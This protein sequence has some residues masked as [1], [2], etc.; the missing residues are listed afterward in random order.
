MNNIEE[1]MKWCNIVLERDEG[2][3]DAVCNKAELH[4][5]RQEYEEA[6]KIYQRAGNNQDRRVSQVSRCHGY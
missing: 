1:G 3:V 4:I 5:G 2:N 6:I